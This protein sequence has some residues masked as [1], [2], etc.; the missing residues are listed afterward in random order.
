MGPFTAKAF[1]PT[2]FGDEKVAQF[3]TQPY[4]YV[5]FGMMLMIAALVALAA[6]V[7]RMKLRGGCPPARGTG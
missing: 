1:M 6:L 4:P 5:G 7:R 3:S 2:V